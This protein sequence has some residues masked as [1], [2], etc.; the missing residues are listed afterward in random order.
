MEQ[1]H[2]GHIRVLNKNGRRS[3]LSQPSGA[4]ELSRIAQLD[5]LE[6]K[7]K[8]KSAS[9]AAG[10]LRLQQGQAEEGAGCIVD[11]K[12]ARPIADVQLPVR[13]GGGAA[14]AFLGR[15]GS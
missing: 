9:V 14:G 8:L 11:G 10:L 13:R 12:D 7:L 6:L 5:I 15:S 1:V 2:L 4:Q 3:R